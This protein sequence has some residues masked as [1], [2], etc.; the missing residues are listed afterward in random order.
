M[1]GLGQY[2]FVSKENLTLIANG[3]STSLTKKQTNY[4]WIYIGSSDKPE[5][6]ILNY[7]EVRISNM[8]DFSRATE[9][10]EYKIWNIHPKDDGKILYWVES[11]S[12]RN[13]YFILDLVSLRKNITEVL[14]NKNHPE[15]AI[16]ESDILKKT[17]YYLE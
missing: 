1:I 3:Q 15:R 8:Y 11:Y 4:I 16:Y 7:A 12:I 9:R 2:R 5:A 6:G 17:I 13:R 10:S 14:Y